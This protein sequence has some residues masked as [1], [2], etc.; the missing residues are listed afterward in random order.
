MIRFTV[1]KIITFAFSYI[2]L[3]AVV[4]IALGATGY[5]DKLLESVIN[6]EL[7]AERIA[8]AQTIQDPGELETIID[9]RYVELREV[10]K[11][12]KPWFVRIPPMMFNILKGNWGLAKSVQSFSGSPEISTIVMERMKNTI[13]MM[14]PSFF[15]VTL[16]GIAVGKW[17]AN[18]AGSRFERMISGVLFSFSAIPAWWFGIGLI[19]ILANGFGWFPPGGMSSTP[20]P[21]GALAGILDTAWHAALP[22]MS[23]AI[24]SFGPYAV[25]IRS[26]TVQ[27]AH[28]P[29]VR[30]ARARGLPERSVQRRYILRP[31]SLPIVTGI[32]LG[33]VGSFSGAI[34]TEAVFNWPGMGQLYLE[35]ILGT[36]DEGLVVALTA[37]YGA[38]FMG[39]RFILEFVYFALDPRLRRKGVH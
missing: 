3:L 33:V 2:V 19:M 9:Q 14:L 28:Q 1:T 13:I 10:H 39:I 34:L 37:M 27:Q 12:D 24:V 17:L 26:M 16:G 21:Q 31:A 23:L 25:T 5:S 6:E 20:P 35:A 38:M 30:F 15:L 22:V 32:L 7:R 18:H 29:V 8:L 11:L 36:P 4:A